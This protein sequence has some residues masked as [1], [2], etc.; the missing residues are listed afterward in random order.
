M[1]HVKGHGA[2]LR[3]RQPKLVAC[4]AAWAFLATL[5][6]LHRSG[7][8]IGNCQTRARDG[9]PAAAANAAAA[10]SAAGQPHLQQQPG[11]DWPE[12][13]G[14]SRERIEAL[15]RAPAGLH[16]RVQKGGLPANYM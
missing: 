2:T 3:V 1:A 15:I 11:D 9:A 4:L 14:L 13:R 8:A 6:C 16:G 7:S 12:L 5:A 10:A